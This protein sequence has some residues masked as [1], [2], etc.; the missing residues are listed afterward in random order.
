MHVGCGCFFLSFSLSLSLSPASHFFVFFVSLSLFLKFFVQLGHP[1]LSRHHVLL[2][3][4]PRF[5]VPFLR[6]QQPTNIFDCLEECVEA[7]SVNM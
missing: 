5:C 2:C 6:Q 1:W 3:I 4:V 7:E